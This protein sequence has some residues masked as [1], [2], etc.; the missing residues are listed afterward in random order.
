MS[1][2]NK[3]PRRAAEPSPPSPRP[4]EDARDA[5]NAPAPRGPLAVMREWTDILVV[6]F[7]L[8]MFVRVFLVEL[9]KIPSSSMTPTLVGGEIA[10]ID[11]NHDGLEDMLALRG[12]TTPLLFLNNGD[13]LV[14]QGPAVGF[15]AFDL[16]RLRLSE[17]VHHRYDRIL[18]NKLA[19]WFGDPK[20]GDIVVFKTPR[21][22]WDPTKP[23][24]IKRCVGETGET[25][26][27]DPEGRLRADGQVVEAPGFFQTQRYVTRVEAMQPAFNY[28]PEMAYDTTRP[29]QPRI[30]RIHVPRGEIYV[31]GDNTHGSLDSR[32]WGGVSIAR[33]KGRAF[34][35][36]WPLAH[37]GS[38]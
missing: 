8:A 10:R 36:Y 9:F 34:W 5:R 13:R 23:V 26:T 38:L 3:K 22:I 4:G 35:R 18:V 21:S 16:K 29:A 17:K 6:A 28:Q 33:V 14:G 24:Y 12:S 32:Y 7:V 20:R 2:K 25:L 31:F 11:A 19:Y 37:I 1:K 27:F 15:S 30:E